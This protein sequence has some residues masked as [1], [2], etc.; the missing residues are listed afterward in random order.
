MDQPSDRDQAIHDIDERLE[1][2]EQRLKEN[3]AGP[4]PT[5]L[6]DPDEGDTERWEAAQVWA[7]MAEF[8][9]YWQ[10]QL[11]KVV[12]N[13]KGEPIPFGRLKDD[14][15]RKDG[16]ESGRHEPITNLMEEVEG[17][18]EGVR[19]YLPTLSDAQWASVGL[20]PRRGEMSVQEMVERF[21]VDHLEEH[22]NQLDSLRS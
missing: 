16:I 2:V 1:V 10:S 4:A 14:T 12:D 8:V 5:G 11:E 15:G 17:G 13:Y 19:R 22:A 20:H 7:H 6:T 3:A 21:T 9:S 18:I